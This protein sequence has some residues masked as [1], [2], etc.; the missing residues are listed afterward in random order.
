MNLF[1]VFLIQNTLCAGIS[2]PM[3]DMDPNPV[4]YTVIHLQFIEDESNLYVPLA[5]D[6]VHIS[7]INRYQDVMDDISLALPYAKAI[8]EVDLEI[9]KFIFEDA[10]K[11]AIEK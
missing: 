1:T 9:T 2:N 6:P 5:L 4:H 10:I 3:L 8:L 7:I 11:E